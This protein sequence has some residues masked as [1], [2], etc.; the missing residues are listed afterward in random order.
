MMDAYAGGSKEVRVD[1]D[2]EGEEER[3]EMVV[4]VQLV[5]L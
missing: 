3:D 4:M 1:I 5:V 2:G